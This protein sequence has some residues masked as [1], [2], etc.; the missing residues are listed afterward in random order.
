MD[1][2][3]FMLKNLD[4]ALVIKRSQE[5]AASSFTYSS[6]TKTSHLLKELFMLWLVLDEE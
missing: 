2:E 3:A 5:I 4:A 6:F 1:I